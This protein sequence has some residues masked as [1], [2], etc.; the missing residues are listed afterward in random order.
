MKSNGTVK[1]EG[2]EGGE[3][4]EGKPHFVGSSFFDLIKVFLGLVFLHHFRF[5]QE[6]WL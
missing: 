2:E 5:L 4:E 6:G 1:E 3:G